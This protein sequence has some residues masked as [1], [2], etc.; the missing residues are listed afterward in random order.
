MT[1]PKQFRQN[2]PS[3]DRIQPDGSVLCMNCRETKPRTEFCACKT[4]DV[5]LDSWCRACHRK[6]N[7]DCY[8][9]THGIPLKA[10]LYYRG[11]RE[12]KDANTRVA[13]FC[14]AWKRAVRFGACRTPEA[15]RETFLTVL[16]ATALCPVPRRIRKKAES[17]FGFKV[18]DVGVAG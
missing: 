10:P 2:L 11:P 3:M 18:V 5:G 14:D 16:A 1:A 7:R 12:P 9:R 15:C 17:P 4:V 6:K 8:R 13:W